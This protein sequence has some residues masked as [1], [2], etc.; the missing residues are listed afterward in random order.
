MWKAQNLEI[1]ESLTSGGAVANV[2][3]SPSTFSFASEFAAYTF[4]AE[5]N[6][7]GNNI[8]IDQICQSH[9]QAVV[10]L[11]DSTFSIHSTLL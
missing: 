10:A 2:L 3:I 5:K 7:L 9:I 11:A 6:F 8:L 4:L 1:L